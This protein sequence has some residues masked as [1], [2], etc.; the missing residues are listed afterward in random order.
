MCVKVKKMGAKN[1]YL[2]LKFIIYRFLFISAAKTIHDVLTENEGNLL[3][4]WQNRNRKPEPKPDYF[5]SNFFKRHDD[6]KD[7]GQKELKTILPI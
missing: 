4:E 1:I 2:F 7:E 6:L 3:E 5:F